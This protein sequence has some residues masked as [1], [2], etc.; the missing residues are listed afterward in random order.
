MSGSSIRRTMARQWE[1][2][3]LLPHRGPG[4]T[5]G[6]LT[7]KL[8]DSGYHV[9]KRTVERDLK[10]LSDVF[11]LC[12]NDKSTPF[13]WYWMPGSSSDLPGIT[14]AEA[15][16][17]QLVEGSIRPL[18]PASMLSAL[19]SRFTQARNK[20][21]ALK[22]EVAS[23]DWINKTAIVLPA[24]SLRT[25]SIDPD[26]L[27]SVQKGLLYDRQ[28]HCSYYSADKD[29]LHELTLNPLGLVQ[30]GQITYLVAIVSGFEDI[31]IYA[32]HRFQQVDVLNTAVEKPADFDLQSYISTGAFEFGAPKPIELVAWVN[33]NLARLLT[34]TP[35]SEDMRLEVLEPTTGGARLT[36]TVNDTWELRWWILSQ[37]GSLR[38]EAPEGLRNEIVRELREGLQLYRAD[39]M[40]FAETK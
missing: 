22:N 28:L 21:K 34:E 25:P 3:K 11:P 40:S 37:A 29:K 6:E 20:L 10:T 7:Q 31:R 23:A 8:R 35:L 16:T 13:G 24:M 4:T 18:I 30:R 33:D 12:C 32:M 36:A 14:M 15:L 5:Y 19:E 1:I 26:V 9:T 38:V 27:E 39:Y 17:L 2:L